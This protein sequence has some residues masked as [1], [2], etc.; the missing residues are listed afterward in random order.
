MKQQDAPHPLELVRQFINTHDLERGTDGLATAAQA[1]QWMAEQRLVDRAERL[2]EPDRQR[3]VA[4]REA[5]RSLADANSPRVA[6]PDQAALGTI[7]DI[8]R[9]ASVQLRFRADGTPDLAPEQDTGVSSALG[10]LVAVVGLAAFDGTWR[11]L[12][13]CPA[14]GCRWAFYDHSKNRSGTW[15]QMA[16]CGNRAK[17]RAFRDR[18][19]T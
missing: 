12:K 3:A 15:C 1:Q 17:V 2:T 9:G 14:E 16:E 13:I 4:L 5:L 18:R 11:R 8:I 6:Q 19:E 10:R 7:R